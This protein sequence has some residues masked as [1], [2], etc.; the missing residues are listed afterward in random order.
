MFAIKGLELK[1]FLSH[2]STSIQFDDETYVILG[3]NGSGKT[4]ILRGIFFGLFGR[5]ILFNKKGLDRL[6][7][8]QSNSMHVAV[9]FLFRNDTYRI[10]RRR[11]VSSKN[12]DVKIFKNGRMHVKG[13]R[14][15]DRFIEDLGIDYNTFKNTIYVPQGELSTFLSGEPKAKRELLNRISGLELLVGRS[16]DITDFRKKL[17][18]QMSVYMEKLSWIDSTLK[19]KERLECEVNNLSKSAEKKQVELKET[20]NL[21][22]RQAL[23]LRSYEEKARKFELLSQKLDLLNSQRERLISDLNDTGKRIERLED[24]EG[25][26]P[27]IEEKL[28]KLPLIEKLYE[29]SSELR[30]IGLE[31]NNLELKLKEIEDKKQ[32]LGELSEEALSLER[33]NDSIEG[34]LKTLEGRYEEDL[35][36]LN[37]LRIKKGKFDLLS[38]R[39]SEKIRDLSN[40]KAE[41]HAIG[42]VDASSVKVKME[43]EERMYSDL[44]SRLSEIRTKLS[45]ERD[46]LELLGKDSSKCPLCG[47]E[48]SDK[49]LE[50]LLNDIRENIPKLSGLESELKDKLSKCKQEIEHLKVKLSLQNRKASDLESKKSELKSIESSVEDLRSEIGVLNLDVTELNKL[51]GTVKD[52]SDSILKLKERRKHNL[53]RLNDIKVRISNIKNSIKDVDL[54]GLLN[55]KNELIKRKEKIIEFIKNSKQKYN[56]NFSNTRDIEGMFNELKEIKDKFNSIRGELKSLPSLRE[57]LEK[58]QREVESV[59]ATLED[60][61]SSINLLSY[62]K[63]EHQTVAETLDKLTEAADLLTEQISDSRGRLNA[64]QE[65]LKRIQSQVLSK[66]TIRDDALNLKYVLDVV[67]LLEKGFHPATG[68]VKSLRKNLLPTL[69]HICRELFENFNF[70]FNDLS[71]SE[72]LAVSF[73]VPNVGTIDLDQ[74]SGGQ[75]MAFAL[76]LRFAMAKQFMQGFNIIMLDEPTIHLDEER[77]RELSNILLSLKG[78]LKQMIIVTHDPELEI[79]GDKVLRLKKVNGV[80]SFV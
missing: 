72:D 69:S 27:K 6:L 19:D 8:T 2:V 78:K 45:E 25:K 59:N 4:S 77:R 29:A 54:N 14:D 23:L 62:N 28:T 16:S 37:L 42:F 11:S 24:L 21:R 64:K 35:A 20:L 66:A 71:I 68:F 5:D 70:D 57:S 55:K 76:A 43:N 26:L 18:S 9:D 60:I 10:E 80:S 31:L 67:K 63:L 65:E 39:L 41:I 46:K 17:E 47:T 75:R 38:S 73:G 13:L 56:L 53:D 36:N 7:N 15:V 22:E 40:K 52:K 30:E 48:L 50:A 44:T 12:F 74:I 79:V 1:G 32:S 34:K 33:L 51:E 58:K 49:R 3:S 61:K